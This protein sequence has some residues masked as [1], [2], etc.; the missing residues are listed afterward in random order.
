MR[1]FEHSEFE[2]AMLRAVNPQRFTPR[3]GKN[4]M[5]QIL[6]EFTPGFAGTALTLP[7]AVRSRYRR[8]LR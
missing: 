5:D 6:K 2:Q 4:R 1:L 8:L 3:P 7:R